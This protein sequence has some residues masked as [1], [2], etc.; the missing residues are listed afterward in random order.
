MLVFTAI[1]VSIG[2][3]ALH[4]RSALPDFREY[5]AGPDRKAAFFEF[6]EPLIAAENARV[7]E[8]RDRLLAISKSGDPGF[9]ER[10]WLASIAE[11]YGIDDPD[12]KD[13]ALLNELLLRVDVVPR[14]L[15]LAQSAKES[16]WGTSRFAREGYNLF[17]EWCFEEGCGI[18]PR[19]RAQEREHEVERFRSPRHSVASYLNNLNSHREY[20]AFRIARARLRNADKPLSGVA[21]AENLTQ[22]SER[23]D[24]YVAEI[25]SLIRNNDLESRYTNDA[26]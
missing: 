20:E 1:V 8:D 23:R 16:G 7:R 17:G 25:R 2:W 19:A 5:I 13:P 24:V 11:D 3:F 21:L 26:N 10:R 6:V 12:P 9:F 15:A 14:S 22:Y 18:V 4:A